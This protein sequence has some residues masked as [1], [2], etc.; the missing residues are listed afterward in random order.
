MEKGRCPE[1]IREVVDGATVYR[2]LEESL[3][4]DWRD[5]VALVAEKLDGS[6]SPFAV[7]VGIILSQNTN[8]RNSIRAYHELRARVGVGLEDILRASL[9]E[10]MDAIRVAGLA[11]QKARA[12]KAAAE[13]VAELGGEKALLEMDWRLLRE[14]LLEV[15]GIGKKTVDVFLSLVRHAPVF[16]VDTHA[17]RIALRWGLARKKSYDEASKALLEFFGPGL[18]EKAHRLLIALGRTYC[19]A[20]GP[21]CSECPLR[22]WCPYA[23]RVRRAERS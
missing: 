12:I 2:V 20:R 18:S 7:L 9:E 11:K 19:R 22:E 6:K 16:A 21:R 14:K 8:D 23:C 3:V 5:Y 10:V 1:S 17:M 4:V 15:P 13:K